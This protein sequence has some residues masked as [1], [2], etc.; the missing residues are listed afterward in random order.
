MKDSEI[1]PIYLQALEWFAKLKDEKTSAEDKQAFAV[2]LKENR[3]HREAFDRAQALWER[4]DIIKPEYERLQR[5]KSLT[6][7]NL[8]IGGLA[9]AIILPGMYMAN[10]PRLFASHTTTIGER[11]AIRLSDG[12]IVELGSYSSLTI[13]FSANER[14]LILHDGQ[15]FFSVAPD[16][17]RPFTVIA[18]E[19]K[20]RALGTQFDV[21][22]IDE[23]VTVTVIEHA[24]NV[25]LLSRETVDVAEGWQVNYFDKGIMNAHRA[26]IEN[27]N[28]WREDKI[29]FEDVPLRI[30][31]R[32]L[33]R[34]RRGRIILMD[35]DIG[36]IP[37]T[38]I[39]E[40]QQ[41]EAALKTIADTLPVRVLNPD[42][43]VAIV[44][45]H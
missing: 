39:F 11:R 12:S 25:E 5:K 17:K 16:R 21:K 1:D 43:L 41:A 15:A 27:T 45:R 38:G 9:S 28:A 32:E 2:W 14:R 18:R 31:L 8:L 37:V 4:F 7:R 23:T 3:S 19:G 33:E 24:V 35:N 29:V 20:I 36:D 26:D 40:T 42:G 34:Y 30:V 44:Y 10:N 22:I 6:R 13:D